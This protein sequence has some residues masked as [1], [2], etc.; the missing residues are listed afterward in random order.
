[1]VAPKE[2]SQAYLR[3]FN[4]V[5]DSVSYK[6]NYGCPNGVNILPALGYGDIQLQAK[7]VEGGEVPV[8]VVK[9]KNKEETIVGV[10]KLQIEPQQ[11]YCILVL[12]NYDRT[13]ET[14]Y[15]YNE[16]SQEIESVV[17]AEEIIE[18]T[19]EARVINMSYSSTSVKT[20]IDEVIASGLPQLSI[21]PYSVITACES[22]TSDEVIF[23]TNGESDT[24]LMSFEVLRKYSFVQ[25]DSADKKGFKKI[26]VPPVLKTIE[27]NDT[28]Y[29]R[30]IN[31]YWQEPSINLSVGMRN[32]LDTIEVGKYLAKQLEFGELG[33]LAIPKTGRVPFT[34]FTSTQPAHLLYS[35]IGQFDA[36]KDYLVIIH[37]DENGKPK[38]AVVEENDE[39][40]AVEFLEEGVFA[41]I[42]ST[43]SE[44]ESINLTLSDS[45]GVFLDNVKIQQGGGISVVVPIGDLNIQANSK[46]LNVTTRADNRLLV[47]I[48]KSGRDL[49]MFEYQYWKMNFGSDYYTRRFINATEDIEELYIREREW[50][51][52]KDPPSAPIVQL[53]QG[54]IS[55]PELVNRENRRAFFMYDAIDSKEE[56]GVVRDLIFSFNKA[57]T[58]ILGGSRE[59]TGCYLILVQE[60]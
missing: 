43:S 11:Q 27:T 15:L 42:I 30:V 6:V 60:Y 10:Y 25:I 18:K 1:M 55:E 40:Q 12:P 20:G 54:E 46:N 3:L 4:G 8:S 58:V 29:V 32:V 23:D 50:E 49:E 14:V 33:A 9:S 16:T 31:A 41:Q 45:D 52:T 48:S 35:A 28:A 56:V 5:N 21:S 34:L 38:I 47:V 19:A 59:G 26:P 24:T 13:A 22:Q 37:A 17:E 51:D 39:D 44:A 36:N 53:R 7:T 57:Y 2:P